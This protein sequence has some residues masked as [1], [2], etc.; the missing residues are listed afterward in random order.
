MFVLF[1]SKIKYKLMLLL[2]TI[3]I[4]TIL[5]SLIAT[6]WIIKTSQWNSLID[7]T[8]RT[9][10]VIETLLKTNQ[11]SLANES[12]LVGELPIFTT[13]VENGDVDTILDTAQGYQNQLGFPIFD[14]RDESG[15]L[16]VSLN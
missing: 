8:T 1:K 6:N 11:S 12:K 14:I 7:A 16:L 9:E 13:V 15:D 10:Q 2:S 3:L 5:I 4:L